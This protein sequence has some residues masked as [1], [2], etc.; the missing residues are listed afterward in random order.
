[1]WEHLSSWYIFHHHIQ[2]G[3]VLWANVSYLY[4]DTSAKCKKKCTSKRQKYILWKRTPVWQEREKR[5]LAIFSS[6]WVCVQFVW[7]SPPGHTGKYTRLEVRCGVTLWSYKYSER[8]PKKDVSCHPLQHSNPLPPYTNNLQRAT[9]A[10][11][12]YITWPIQSYP[13]K[14]SMIIQITS[15]RWDFW[16]IVFKYGTCKV[17]KDKH[18]PSACPGFSWRRTALILWVLPT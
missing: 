1:M 7:V 18:P 6:H 2:V 16:F 3:V 12:L 8:S 15:G 13:N 9:G 10:A 4:H 14:G 17:T 5:Q 11:L